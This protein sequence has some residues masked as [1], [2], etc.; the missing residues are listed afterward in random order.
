M[1]NRDATEYNYVRI[2]AVD[3]IRKVRASIK[4]IVLEAKISNWLMAMLD[5]I[6]IFLTWK[7][8]PKSSKNISI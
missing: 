6:R 1:V 5:N 8:P 7:T 4:L 3:R 2:R